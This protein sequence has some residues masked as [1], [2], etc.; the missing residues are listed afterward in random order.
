MDGTLIEDEKRAR[1]AVPQV[2][3][4]REVTVGEPLMVLEL[5]SRTASLVVVKESQGVNV[6]IVGRRRTVGRLIVQCEIERT[7][8]NH[9]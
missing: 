2:D 4:T 6:V 1:G 7:R 8:A 5:E 9:A 3:V